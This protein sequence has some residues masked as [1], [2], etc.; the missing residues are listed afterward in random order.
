M[1][2]RNGLGGMYTMF[3]RNERIVITMNDQR[4]QAQLGQR[5]MAGSPPSDTQ[6]AAATSH[7]R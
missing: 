2:S 3:G 5:R 4:W 1:G 6:P 7:L